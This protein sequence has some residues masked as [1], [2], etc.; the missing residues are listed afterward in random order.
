M[1][2]QQFP[3]LVTVFRLG[4]ARKIFAGHVR[5]GG[6]VA[7]HPVHRPRYGIQRCLKLVSPF[8]TFLEQIVGNTFE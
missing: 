7:A 5:P 6:H 2:P 1:P 8:Q 3:G 4:A